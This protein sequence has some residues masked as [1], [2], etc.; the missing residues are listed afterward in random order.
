[1]LG[2]M[3]RASGLV[4]DDAGNVSKQFMFYLT[5]PATLITNFAN[6]SEITP[7]LLL[8]ALC[9]FLAN[10]FMLG[11]GM[12]LTRGC[13]AGVRALY[14]INLPS[15]NVGAFVI[16]FVQSFLPPLGNVTTCFFDMGNSVVCTGASYSFTAEYLSGGRGLRGIRVKALVKRLLTSPPLMASLVMTLLMLLHLQ[17]PG[18][19]LTLIQP[20]A[21]ANPF[22]AMLTLGLMFRL[23]LKREYLGQIFKILLLRI[24]IGTACALAFYFLLPFEAV[25]RQALVL[26]SFAPISAVA[27]AFTGMCGGDQGLASAVNSVTIICSLVITT[28]LLGVMGLS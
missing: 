3:M 20:L 26:I 4:D 7:R 12:F 23:E 5:I 8:L 13:S 21:S 27:P 22:V 17:L 11:L 24:S 15:F 6:V 2:I 16:P 19:V 18:A 1:M 25:V 14:M 10:V 9:G 28:F